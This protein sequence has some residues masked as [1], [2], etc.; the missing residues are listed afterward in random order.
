M[1][2]AVST[3]QTALNC[4]VHL[5]AELQKYLLAQGLRSSEKGVR[6]HRDPCRQVRDRSR[7]VEVDHLHVHLPRVPKTPA[8]IRT[9]DPEQETARWHGERAELLVQVGVVAATGLAKP[10]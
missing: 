2:G 9:T 3:V 7:E 8:G 6:P 5:C 4:P 10:R 1:A